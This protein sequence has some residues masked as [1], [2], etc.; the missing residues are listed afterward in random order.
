MF[1]SSVFKVLT[2][3][4]V[5]LEWSNLNNRSTLI[6]PILADFFFYHLIQGVSLLATVAVAL[7]YLASSSLTA[8]AASLSLPPIRFSY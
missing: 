3:H 6:R 1:C 5:V 2:I 4:I 8:I 7:T